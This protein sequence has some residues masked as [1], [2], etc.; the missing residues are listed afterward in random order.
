MRWFLFC[1]KL[2]SGRP[3]PEFLQLGPQGTHHLFPPHEDPDLLIWES[4]FDTL[5]CAMGCHEGLLCKAIHLDVDL[6]VLQRTVLPSLC[7]IG[8]W[9]HVFVLHAEWL[10]GNE[11]FE[12][13]KNNCLWLI[14]RKWAEGF[15]PMRNY[16]IVITIDHNKRDCVIAF[17]CCCI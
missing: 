16:P 10:S 13:A 3:A 6:F 9:L 4:T 8:I 17:G 15:L 1:G 7:V 2:L 11:V 12:N 14:G 5:A